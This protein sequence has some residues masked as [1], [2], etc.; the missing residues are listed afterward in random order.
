MYLFLATSL[1]GEPIQELAS[2]EVAG[3]V[4]K[5]VVAIADKYYQPGK[6]TTFVRV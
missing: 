4:W 6:F 5:Q 2:P 3:G 1:L